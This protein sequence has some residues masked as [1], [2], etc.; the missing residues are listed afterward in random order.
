MQNEIPRIPETIE[1]LRAWYAAHNLP[2]EEVT[3]F[4]IG[5]DV[6]EPRAFGIYQDGSLFIV[7]KNKNDGSRAVRYSGFD[8]KFAVRELYEKLKSEIANQKAASAAK[9]PL[10]P[11]Q[12]R[13]QRR[14]FIIIALIIAAVIA[15]SVWKSA[16]TPN[17]GYYHVDNSWYYYCDGWYW[18][19]DYTGGWTTYD[20][21]YG[22][23]YWS[24]YYYSESYPNGYGVYDFEL[25]DYYSQVDNDSSWS[26]DS[27]WDSGSSD[28][29]SDWH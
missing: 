8:E 27:D 4:F 14:T 12:Q 10:T 29:D 5:R 21:G 15:Y 16:N 7:Y 9:A 28:F 18:Y 25:T 13:S 6:Q 2:P 22:N 24:G 19:N 1:Q 3:R 20:T 17:R 26:S 23:D 11:A